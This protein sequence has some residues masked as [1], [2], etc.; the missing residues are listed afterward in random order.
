MPRKQSLFLACL[1]LQAWPLP[2]N[3]SVQQRLA[4]SVGSLPQ[5]IGKLDYR[6]LSPDSQRQERHLAIQMH[7]RGL[8]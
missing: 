5:L 6:F 7:L 1:P 2:R 8:Y 3:A 4:L